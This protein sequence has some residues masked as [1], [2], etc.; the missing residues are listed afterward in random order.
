MQES[1]LA[2]NNPAEHTLPIRL[3]SIRFD[4]ISFDN[5]DKPVNHAQTSVFPK[6]RIARERQMTK[7]FWEAAIAVIGTARLDQEDS[8]TTEIKHSRVG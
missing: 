2:L 3:D 4:S 6:T 1:L 5:R 8:W 7:V